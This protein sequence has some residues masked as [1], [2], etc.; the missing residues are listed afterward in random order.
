MSTGQGSEQAA[1]DNITGRAPAIRP[2]VWEAGLVF[3]L[4]GAFTLLAARKLG[5]FPAPWK[6][7]AWLMQPAYELMAGGQICLPMFRHMGAQIG[8]LVMSDPVF[9]ALLALWFR[10]FGFGLLSARAFNLAL[11]AGALLTVYFLARR[12][13]GPGAGAIA[14]VMLATDNNFFTGARFLRN[15]FAS[16][17]FALLAACLYVHAR[18]KRHYV[19]AGLCAAC[20]A[21]SHLNGSY[22]VALLGIWLL[23]GHGWRMIKTPQAW[24]SALGLSIALV[25]YA[26][27][28]FLH[29]ETY[30]AQ[31]R[32]FT[33]G[34]E[35]GLTSAGIWQ[36]ISAEPARYLN[37]HYGVLSSTNYTTV[38]F[39]Q[40]LTV[41]ALVALL[42]IVMRR[43]WRRQPLR[44]DGCLLLLTAIVWCA[45]FFA[46]E[47]VNKTHS[48]LPH[49]TSWFAIAIG[50]VT[51]DL[52]SYIK[53]RYHRR[54]AVAWAMLLPAG[55]AAVLFLN[56]T[57]VMLA[58][59]WRYS[60]T[61][62]AHSYNRMCNDLGEVIGPD[63]IPVGSPR[64]WYLFARRDDYRAF[65][66]P[67]S[68][69][70]LKGDFPGEQ[71]ALIVN[72]RERKKFL[73]VAEQL[74]EPARAYHL[75][76]ELADTPYGQLWIYY[77]GNDPHY[78][79]RATQRLSAE[80]K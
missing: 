13:R 56:S 18:N 52:C 28:C 49:L 40:F 46:A 27:Y 80:R 47:V 67:L 68:R 26:I 51:A 57:I 55:I 6:D 61:L 15:D 78:L 39:F 35:K 29:R 23:I 37:W 69:R 71:Y 54:R 3:A 19:L 77:I 73:A 2:V 22:A 9:T 50:V 42:A 30:L 11:A 12:W 8:E 60:G 58:R 72:Q 17:L 53:S 64:H 43:A 45:L 5:F 36:N 74:K 25:P 32:L 14:L 65:S 48:Y 10:I 44:Q 41:L 33:P 24:L 38:Y 1:P 4:V 31:W 20:A 70:I 21:L 75:L 59:Y 63:L 76:T 16:L 7:E 79:T 62:T 34:R 66:R